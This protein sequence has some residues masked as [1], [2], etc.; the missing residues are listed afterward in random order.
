MDDNPQKLGTCLRR[1]L[2]YVRGQIIGIKKTSMLDI[3]IFSILL[4]SPNLTIIVSVGQITKILFCQP[5]IAIIEVYLQKNFHTAKFYYS[6]ANPSYQN[7]SYFGKH[8]YFRD[9]SHTFTVEGVNYDIRNYIDAFQRRSKGFFH[10]L[11]TFKAVMSIFVIAYN[12][13]GEFKSRF[14]NLKN[15]AS[16]IYFIPSLWFGHSRGVGLT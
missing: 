15:S 7:V 6:D 16:L 8:Y 2:Y 4:T 12:K 1:T 3:L 14:P 9:K 13:F 11:N 10:S 5:L